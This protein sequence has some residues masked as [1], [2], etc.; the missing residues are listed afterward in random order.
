MAVVILGGLFSSTVLNLLV[1]P[2][3]ALRFARFAP[4]EKN[5]AGVTYDW[6]LP[7]GTVPR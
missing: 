3:L 4:P 5:A 1:L 6:R 7:P 2:V